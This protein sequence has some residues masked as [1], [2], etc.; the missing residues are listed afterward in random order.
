LSLVFVRD[1]AEGVVACL[2]NPAAAGR[3]YFA[4]CWEVVTGRELADE[5]IRQMGGWGIPVHVPAAVLWPVCVL[6][7]MVS[8]LTGKA[9]LLNRQK[10][11]ELTAPGWVCDAS[12][13]RD[14][15]GYECATR[16]K[17][18]VGETLGWYRQHKWL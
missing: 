11:E 2:E 13:L 3:V 14:E 1:L 18:G 5:I 9:T 17:Q 10:F 8:R 4:A 12:R 6:G 16:L 15:I 7:G